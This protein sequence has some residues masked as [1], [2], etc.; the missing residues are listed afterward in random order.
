MIVLF[1]YPHSRLWSNVGAL[2]WYAHR[3]LTE[4][5][6]EDWPDQMCY[7]WFLS[8]NGPDGQGLNWLNELEVRWFYGKLNHI[9]RGFV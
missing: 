7:D 8:D 2:G 3:Q 9:F 4:E 5:K 6:G 1:T